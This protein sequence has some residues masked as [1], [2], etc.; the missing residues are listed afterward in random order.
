MADKRGVGK[1]FDQSLQHENVTSSVTGLA[2]YVSY[3]YLQLVGLGVVPPTFAIYDSDN[4]ALAR[5][6][7]LRRFE[8]TENAANTTS[9]PGGPFRWRLPQDSSGTR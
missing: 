1:E 2:A 9:L 7:L 5:P 3:S 6:F 4:D 8:S